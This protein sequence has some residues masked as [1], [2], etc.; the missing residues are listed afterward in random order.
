MGKPF[1]YFN[2]SHKILCLIIHK[3]CI[4]FKIDFNCLIVYNNVGIWLLFTM[5]IHTTGLIY[6]EIVLVLS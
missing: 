6:E 3:K 4:P 5:W 1:W 2:N